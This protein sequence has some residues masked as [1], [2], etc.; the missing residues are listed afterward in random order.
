M[1]RDYVQYNLSEAHEA[2][3]SMIADMQSNREFGD[4]A[5]N[6]NLTHVY[7]HLNTAWNARDA[8]TAATN[9]CSEED[10]RRWRQF[11]TGDIFLEP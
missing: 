10:F 7:H 6:V 4:P 5:F 3:G 2:L 1:N 9:E 11:P 8:T